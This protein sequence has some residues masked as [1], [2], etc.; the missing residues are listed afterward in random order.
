MKRMGLILVV[1]LFALF[2][3]IGCGGGG[4]GGGDNFI[5]KT[6][7]SGIDVGAYPTGDPNQGDKVSAA[8]AEELVQKASLMT[9]WISTYGVDNGV[10]QIPVIAKRY[11]LKTAVGCWIT[12]DKTANEVQLNKLFTLIDGGYVDVA[13]IGS[14]CIYR[15]DLYD[16]DLI[17]YINRVKAKGVKVTTRDTWNSLVNHPSVG[18]AC[19]VIYA[20]VHPYWEGASP[21]TAVSTNV[22]NAYNALKATYGDKEIVIAEIGWPSGGKYRPLATPENAMKVFNDFYTWATLNNVKYFYFEL[23]DE[24]WKTNEGEVGPHWG[25]LDKDLKWKTFMEGPFK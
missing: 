10:E 4:T 11:G 16:S 7:I 25:I 9:N 20:N 8:T 13:I 3:L 12:N 2:F 5:P 18:N 24:T 21:D 1:A 15:G 14:E 23:C 19:D 17:G 22:V 6:K